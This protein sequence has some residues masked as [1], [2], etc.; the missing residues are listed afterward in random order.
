VSGELAGSVTASPGP[1]VSVE[2]GAGVPYAG[3]V[4]FGGTRNRPYVG[5]GRNLFPQAEASEPMVVAAVQTATESEIKGMTW[6][7]PT[8]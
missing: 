2:I 5:S 7:T 4:T 6:Q 8:T 1:P 3:W